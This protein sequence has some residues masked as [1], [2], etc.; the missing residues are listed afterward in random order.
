MVPVV[1]E[2]LPRLEYCSCD[3]AAVACV[4][5]DETADTLAALQT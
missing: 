4:K 5:R 1:I 2:G 3:P